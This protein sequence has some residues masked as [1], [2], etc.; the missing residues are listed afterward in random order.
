MSQIP[1]DTN[2][3]I[4]FIIGELKKNRLDVMPDGKFVR[5]TPTAGLTNSHPEIYFP[6]LKPSPGDAQVS[7]GPG[8]I[9]FINI[10]LETALMY[11]SRLRNRTILRP[12]G[13]PPILIALRI[14]LPSPDKRWFMPLKPCLP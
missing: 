12:A 4:S 5:I 1:A 11:Y 10:D 2:A 9:N 13:S 8:Q 14:K 7:I 6:S 3:A